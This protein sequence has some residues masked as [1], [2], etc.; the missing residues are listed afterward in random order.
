[1]V[2]ACAA[3]RPGDDNPG[4]V[5]GVVLGAAARDGVD[6]LTVVDLA[7]GRRAG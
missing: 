4:L 6:K 7:G 2:D 1:M 3:D 5:L